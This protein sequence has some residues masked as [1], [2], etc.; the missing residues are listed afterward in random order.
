MKSE[1]ELITRIFS[2]FGTK[3]ARK[4]GEKIGLSENAVRSWQ[5]ISSP[6][7]HLQKII[8]VTGCDANWLLSGKG[9]PFPSEVEAPVTVAPCTA[10]IAGYV[11][12]DETGGAYVE[13]DTTHI[14]KNGSARVYVRVVGSSMEPIARAGQYLRIVERTPKQGDLVVC[15]YA[16]DDDASRTVAKRWLKTNGDVFLSCVAV[17][18]LHPPIKLKAEKIIETWIVVGVEYEEPE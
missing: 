6:K 2:A 8:E 1:K 3:N 16:L 15:R 18:P 5:N 11:S 4:I 13:M 17:P 10:V 7:R 14:I 12:A 9:E